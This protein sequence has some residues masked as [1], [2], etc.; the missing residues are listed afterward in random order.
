[1]SDNTNS[2]MQFRKRKKKNRNQ[3]QRESTKSKQSIKS[4][5][6]DNNA[7]TIDH[8]RNHEEDDKEECKKIANNDDETTEIKNNNE[9]KEDEDEDEDE[10]LSFLNK[11]KETK[12]VHKLQFQS[13]DKGL[14]F[15]ENHEFTSSGLENPD[16]FRHVKCPNV[17][18]CKDRINAAC[19]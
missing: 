17:R 13:K 2:T 5:T 8:N 1:M 19:A 10:D 9:D 18:W 12:T 11:L 6:S 7:D 3:K 4:V 16:N 15:E 14:T